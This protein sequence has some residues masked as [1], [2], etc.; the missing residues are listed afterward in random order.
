MFVGLFDEHKKE[1]SGC[2]YRRA[3]T[4]KD[5]IFTS[6]GTLFLRWPPATK[7][8]PLVHYCALFKK[9]TDA[10]SVNHAK[11]D[12]PKKLKKRDTIIVSLVD[13]RKVMRTRKWRR[14]RR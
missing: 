11:F 6:K 8:W 10:V 2:G 9:E 1:L 7:R 12:P 14:G 3:S 4:T 13:F 5:R